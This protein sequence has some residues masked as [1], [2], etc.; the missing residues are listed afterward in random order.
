[1]FFVYD[2]V[3]FDFYFIKLNIYI[4]LVIYILYELNLVIYFLYMDEI[5]EC[6]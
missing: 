2:Y 5:I 6:L 3:I 1:M 4:S